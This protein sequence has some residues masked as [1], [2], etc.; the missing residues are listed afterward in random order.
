MKL[1]EEYIQLSREERQSHLD[2]NQACIERGG[3][4][5][6]VSTYC[7]GLL[8]H[9]FDTSI[10]T[11]NKIYVCHA[12]NNNK[13]F[14]LKH[15][16]WGTATENVQDAIIEGTHHSVTR[17]NM[18]PHYFTTEERKKGLEKIRL[19]RLKRGGGEVSLRGS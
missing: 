2:L 10:P 18:K 13:C 5:R 12:C 8:A 19:N 17:K 15:L 11:G 7:R 16:Y 6:L 9:I 4:S 3:P 1:I 14:N